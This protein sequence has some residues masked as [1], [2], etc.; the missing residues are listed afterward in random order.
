MIILFMVFLCGFL[1]LLSNFSL[2]DLGARC[3]NLVAFL[4]KGA[5]L[6]SCH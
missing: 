2:V 5:T 4:S 6:C 1:S 3:F